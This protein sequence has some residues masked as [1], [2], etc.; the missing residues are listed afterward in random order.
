MTTM[1]DRQHALVVVD[2]QRD[3]LPGGALAVP[4]GDEV[5]PVINRLMPRFE[6]VVATQDWHP[7]DHVSFAANHPGREPFESIE[8]D[9]APQ[10]LWPT[11]CVQESTGA[12]FAPGLK[13]EHF[14]R[15]FRKG[16]D[17]RCDS[18]S[19]FFDN[20]HAHD[21]GLAGYLREHG[22][23]TVHVCGLATDYCVRFTALD[24]L[25]EGFDVVLI[26]DA[27]RG[28]DLN[29][30]DIDNTLAELKR[31]GVAIRQSERYVTGEIA[32]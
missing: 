14:A 23:K 31:R 10:T 9:G 16:V 28:V 30:G 24:A 20:R 26:A 22:V 11:H 27:C 3:F 21:T 13:V 8:L 1:L 17:P 19:G 6:L 12:D 5:V 15:V 7:P 25:D 4:H 18:Y 29:P 32:S 2:V